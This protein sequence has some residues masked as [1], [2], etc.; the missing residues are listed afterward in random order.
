LAN[1]VPLKPAKSCIIFE[2]S[3]LNV[4]VGPCPIDEPHCISHWGHDFR[5]E[6]RQ[7]DAL[8]EAEKAVSGVDRERVRDRDQRQE[9]DAG[10]P[11][12]GEPHGTINFNRRPR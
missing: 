6:Y 7:L 2:I 1:P 5:P 10:P 12:C 3:S 9:V 11:A 8:K 4:G